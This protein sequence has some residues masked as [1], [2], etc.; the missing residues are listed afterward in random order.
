M[1]EL[2]QLVIQL[3]KEKRAVPL[4]YSQS[5]LRRTHKADEIICVYP[6]YQLH[7]EGTL[8]ISGMLKPYEEAIL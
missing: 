1:T 6:E 5:V 4:E 7:T 3:P 8:D 2:S